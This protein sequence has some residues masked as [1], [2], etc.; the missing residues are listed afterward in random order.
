[1]VDW[2]DENCG[3]QEAEKGTGK[4][5][6]GWLL[7]LTKQWVDASVQQRWEEQLWA[8]QCTFSW[9][10]EDQ[11]IRQEKGRKAHSANGKSSRW[12]GPGKDP[13]QPHL[14]Q[15]RKASHR[16]HFPQGSCFIC[17]PKPLSIL[18]WLSVLFLTFTCLIRS[19][20]RNF[21]E[22]QMIH[23]SSFPGGA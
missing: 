12:A 11:S 22:A 4:A 10:T 9:Q 23:V 3:C 16:L 20:F 19:K 15:H 13:V 21:W 5:S 18:V 1:M 7:C 6:P 8:A 2:D 17:S 14:Q